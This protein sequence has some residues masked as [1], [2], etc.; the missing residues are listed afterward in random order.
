[1]LPWYQNSRIS[2]IF[3]DRDG[4]L[5][6]QKIEE[7]YGLPFCSLVQSCTEKSYMFNFSFFS[8]IIAG[9]WFVEI[10]PKKFC[11]HGNMT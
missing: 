8:G 9:P 11:Y 4:H 1:M 10:D 2:T 5:H 3:L 7:K 6:Y